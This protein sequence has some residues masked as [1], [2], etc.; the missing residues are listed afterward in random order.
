MATTG[1]FKQ[2]CPSCEAPVLIKDSSLVGK[3]VECPKCKYRFAVE[4]P[5]AAEEVDSVEDTPVS[6]PQPKAA[7]K[8][9]AEA[10]A[11]KP[12]ADTG[13]KAAS[14]E[15]PKSAANGPAVKKKAPSRKLAEDDE[16]E[17][18][19][20]QARFKKKQKGSGSSNMVL[21]AGGGLAVVALGLLGVGAF[22]M[23]GTSENKNGG[24]ARNRPTAP[25]PSKKAT[26]AA[27]TVDA[28]VD[29]TNLLPNESEQVILLDAHNLLNSIIGN[30]AFRSP[31]AFQKKAI[32]E[33][34]GFKLD[35]VERVVYGGNA[36]QKWEFFAIRTTKPINVQALETTLQL[37][38]A[39]D[40]PIKGQKYYV[41]PPITWMSNLAQNNA[42]LGGK[43]APSTYAIRVVDPQTLVVAHPD[44]MRG[45][46]N[47]LGK[48]KVL[49]EEPK[50]PEGATE[51]K[52]P[53][54]GDKKG[55]GPGPGPAPLPA[56]LASTHYLTIKPGLKNVLDQ[57]EAKG[58][59]L[60]TVALSSEEIKSSMAKVPP[61]GAGMPDLNSVLALDEMT[62]FGCAFQLKDRWGMTLA[63][64]GRNQ[65]LGRKAMDALKQNAGKFS[66]G[67]G[68]PVEMDG[69]KFTPSAAVTP[70]K[71]T[72]PVKPAPWQALKPRDLKMTTNLIGNTLV[73]TAEIGVTPELNTF[74][75]QDWLQTGMVRA[76][77]EL[78]M[79]S[80][81][82]R[83]FDLGTAAAQAAKQNPL[84]GAFN[85]EGAS[86]GRPYPPDQRVSWMA[87]LLPQLGHQDVYDGIKFDRSWRPEKDSVDN[88][89]MGS[90]LIP[91]F[92]D[93]TSPEASW[94]VS[95]PSMPDRAY[96]ATSFVGV[97]GV[98]YDAA[99]YR[100]DDPAVA[101][102]LGVFGYDRETRL[103]DV[104][105]GLANTIMM[106]QVPPAYK[107]PWIA[108]G[109]ATVAGIP[110][111]Q[112]V[113]PFVSGQR[114]G[115]KG[116]YVIM[117]DGSVRFVSESISDDVFKGMAT[118]NGGEKND[119][120]KDAPLVK[121]PE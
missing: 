121:K 31:G 53:R 7:A 90:V 29:V 38:D 108:G 48:P 69:Q 70:P 60:L 72:E 102:K 88:A 23:F 62:A 58:P 20:E 65:D 79:K 25:A 12:A 111:K 96:A 68:I 77:G 113:A 13:V 71:G 27:P 107:R 9:P 78:D 52:G 22:F 43:A 28:L 19:E 67:L 47:A 39:E 112:S 40:S 56:K 24:N 104:K 109:G 30:A 26:E 118:I 51:P 87:Q 61:Q 41:T 54:P 32:E 116:T 100:A 84:R 117:L 83:L 76:R 6:K 16:E 45:F 74:V 91:A 99:D 35:E 34:I 4:S 86:L 80:G 15:G 114:D 17:E 95:F 101:N 37:K 82:V 21:I 92:L 63:M 2:V 46:L 75:V 14:A 103:E 115:K 1:S 66:E 120:N 44:P 94:M 57:I 105:D 73:M 3:K 11:K 64:E 97:A 10:A 33:M 50:A 93:P 110:E 8:K 81:K 59:S 89:R 55:P 36:S 18:A 98:G 42:A 49:S 119:F 106:I 5:K 85:R